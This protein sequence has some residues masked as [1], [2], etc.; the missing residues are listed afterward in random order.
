M[1]FGSASFSFVGSRER[2]SLRLGIGHA[3]D[4]FR[5]ILVDSVPRGTL[6]ENERPTPSRERK[7]NSPVGRLEEGM[8]TPLP[9]VK[10]VEN[11]DQ[12]FQTKA[13]VVQ[14]RA[15]LGSNSG[16]TV[17]ELARG[18]RQMRVVVVASQKGGSGKT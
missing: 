13:N 7:V 1:G 8:R 9:R 10:A 17:N 16:S 14:L 15:P 6:V 3:F 18:S 12:P 4:W 11:E 5:T 2:G